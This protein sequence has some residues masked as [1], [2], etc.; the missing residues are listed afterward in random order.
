MKIL[1]NA[2]GITNSGGVVVL[3]K[4]ILELMAAKKNLT[5]IFLVNKNIQVDGLIKKYK[6]NISFS[7]RSLP[8]ANPLSRLFYENIRLRKLVI[9]ENISL[10]YNFS[11]SRQFFSKTPQ[12]IKV[13]NLLFYSKKLDSYYL[14]NSHIGLWIKQIFLRGVVFRFMLRH[15]K[16]LE[17]QSG[18]VSRQLADFIDLSKKVVYIKSDVDVSSRSFSAPRNYDFGKKIKFLYIV[19]PHFEY[20]HKNISDF[21]RAMLELKKLGIDFQIDITLAS[22]QLNRSELWDE[23]LNPL[24]S[25]HGYISDSKDM[26]ELFSD[27]TILISTS[28]IET[29]GLHVIEAIKNGVVIIT[30]NEDYAVEVYGAM[31]FGYDLLDPDSLCR[32]V[33]N[34]INDKKSLTN[35]ILARQKYLRQNEMVKINDIVN[36]FDDVLRRQR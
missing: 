18:H 23:S 25:F 6:D 3:E 27:N 9:E 21:T 19:G 11:G 34:V 7:F 20:P 35:S 30:P 4:L 5:F 24:T 10:V 17:I 14:R 22:D 31:G 12:L 33:V 15:S 36:V 8:F 1:I 16:Y 2:A 29:L 13:Q 28:I 32:T 26:D